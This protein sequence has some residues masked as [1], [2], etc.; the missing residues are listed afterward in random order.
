MKYT[1]GQKQGHC[2]TAMQLLPGQRFL[3]GAGLGV[4]RGREGLAGEAMIS[5]FHGVGEVPRAIPGDP[6]RRGD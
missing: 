1:H 3:W 5:V 6:A 4:C 2:F